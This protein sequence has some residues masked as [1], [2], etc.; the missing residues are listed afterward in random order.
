MGVS[1]VGL[2]ARIVLGFTG[3]YQYHIEPV[4]L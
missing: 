1:L 3:I 4:T 2:L